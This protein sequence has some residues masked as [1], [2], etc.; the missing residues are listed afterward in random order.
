MNLIFTAFTTKKVVSSDKMIMF[1]EAIG[2]VVVA[3]FLAKRVGFISF[4]PK[5]EEIV[6]DTI[7][8]LQNE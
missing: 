5:V 6:V 8:V 1:A 2:L 7:H 3:G 4:V